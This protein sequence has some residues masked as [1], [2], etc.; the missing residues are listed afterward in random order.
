MKEL[1]TKLIVLL[2]LATTFTA[3]GG[4]SNN[5]PPVYF[6]EIP[7]NP[8]LVMLEQRVEGLRAQLAATQPSEPG[9]A[10][11]IVELAEQLELLI[12]GRSQPESNNQGPVHTA[13][14]PDY[15]EVIDLYLQLVAEEPTAVQAPYALLQAGQLVEEAG[16][17]EAGPIFGRIVYEYPESEQV[18]EACLHLGSNAFIAQAFTSAVEYMNCAKEANDPGIAN[19]ANYVLGWIHYNLADFQAALDAFELVRQDSPSSDMLEAT[20]RDMLLVMAP[21]EDGVTIATETFGSRPEHLS[22]LLSIFSGTG[23]VDEF[24]QLLDYLL[25]THPESSEV[26]AWCAEAADVNRQVGREGVPAACGSN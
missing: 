1:T 13:V 9:R 26:E 2:A 5:P 17:E 22:L 8:E 7:A 16:G 12:Y 24:D 18:P 20:E 25:E 15:T 11:L 23:Q 3:C 4:A 19:Y 6:V 21:M 10:G 14:L